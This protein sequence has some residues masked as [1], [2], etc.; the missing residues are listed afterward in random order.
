MQRGKES[1]LKSSDRECEFPEW[2]V[3]AANAHVSNAKRGASGMTFITAM[4]PI[5]NL[6][7]SLVNMTGGALRKL[8]EAHSATCRNR[9]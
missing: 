1:G 8:G 2:V 6:L 3:S 7:S 5:L 4:P 9:T